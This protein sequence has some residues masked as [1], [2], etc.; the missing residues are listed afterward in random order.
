MRRPERSRVAG[1]S[2]PRAPSALVGAALA[3]PT[4]IGDFTYGATLSLIIRGRAVV[5]WVKKRR[6]RRPLPAKRQRFV[7]LRERREHQC[8]GPRARGLGRLGRTGRAVDLLPGSGHRMCPAARASGGSGDQ[9][10][11]P[12]AG[13]ADRD[14]RPPPGET[15]P[16]ADRRAQPSFEAI[17][18]AA[19]PLPDCGRA[20]LAPPPAACACPRSSTCPDCRGQFAHGG[21]RRSRA[22]FSPTSA[23]CPQPSE[24]CDRAILDNGPALRQYTAAVM[25]EL[26]E[27]NGSSIARHAGDK[28]PDRTQR[29]LNHVSWD[30]LAAMGVV[31]RFAVAGLEE[32][33]R[34]G[35][36]RRGLVI[37]AIDETGQE[38]A[39][40]RRFRVRQGLLRLGPVLGPP[41]HRDPPPRRAGHG[42]PG[43]LQ[44]HRRA[45]ER[46][47]RHPGAAPTRPDQ[48]PPPEPGM[49]PLTIPEIKRLLAALTT[50]P[51]PPAHIIHWDAW[52][53]RHQARSRWFHK[54]A[55]L[56]R[57]AKIA[58]VS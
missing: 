4:R 12:V 53:R 20:R 33:A 3:V 27:R 47:H 54:R 56:T 21:R 29:L 49:I 48:P 35:H 15:E 24:R 39:G 8:R 6:G 38:K 22:S 14:C 9:L 28:T 45:A 26:P 36:R 37:R 34:R 13:R 40:E 1:R 42:R 19:C 5:S 17:T 58:Q 51:W 31:R 7:E 43:D 44:R 57:D 41:V 32:A 25:S 46:P 52:T 55:R 2:E 10:R 23:C 30:T 50:R 18:C 16:A 11:V